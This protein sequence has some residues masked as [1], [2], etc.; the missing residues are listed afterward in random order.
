MYRKNAIINPSVMFRNEKINSFY[1]IKF[2]IFNDYYTYAFLIFRGN[3]LCNLPDKLIKY[4][5]NRSGATFSKVKYKFSVNMNIKNILVSNFGYK[6]SIFDWVVVNLQSLLINI[7]PEFVLFKI[8][9][10]I[11]YK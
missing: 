6:P 11:K 3:K 4:R 5:V 1:K 8:Y 9:S 10:F 7:I 2:P